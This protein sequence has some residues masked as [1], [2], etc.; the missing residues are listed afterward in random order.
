MAAACSCSCSLAVLDPRVGHTMDVL[1][2]F[3]TV[4]SHSDWLT[5]SPVH[6]MMLSIQAVRGRPRLR[7]PGIVPCIISISRQLPCFLALTLSNSFFFT[8]A[9]LWTHSFVF[10]AVH[11]TRRIFLSPFI[12]KASRHVSLFLHLRVQ[13]SQ[14]Y[15]AIGHTSA[16]V[17]RIFAEIGML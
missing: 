16:F 15:V 10:F 6:V 1:S 4:L 8:P 9:L 7:A 12:S 17:S 11:E 5:E 14:P 3:I 2:L 13:L